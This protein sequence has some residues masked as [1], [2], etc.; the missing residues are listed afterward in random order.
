MKKPLGLALLAAL[1]S[2]G[3]F[4]DSA[5]ASGRKW[6]RSADAWGPPY[7][8]C[9]TD[10]LEG[11][12]RP[13]HTHYSGPRLCES[14]TGQDLTGKDCSAYAAGQQIKTMYAIGHNFRCVENGGG[15]PAQT[16]A[17]DLSQP[18]A[19][20]CLE[21]RAPEF[22]SF[23][24]HT[25]RKAVVSAAG[26]RQFRGKDACRLQAR[27]TDHDGMEFDLEYYISSEQVCAVLEGGTL[28]RAAAP[29]LE[30]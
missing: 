11:Q 14:P 21:S 30:K 4:P 5:L 9:T 15:A 22:S 7:C 28:C 17:W 3:A 8:H 10:N 1:V 20:W 18:V 26:V 12:C 24:R 29:E 23:I 25:G 19:R 6:V 27:A 2:L 16:A 13:E